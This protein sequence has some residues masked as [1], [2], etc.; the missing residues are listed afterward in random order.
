M[1]PHSLAPYHCPDWVTVRCG[2]TRDNDTGKAERTID[3]PTSRYK[4]PT[5]QQ[6]RGSEKKRKKKTSRATSHTLTILILDLLVGGVTSGIPTPTRPLCRIIGSNAK[7]SVRE[8]REAGSEAQVPE[9]QGRPEFKISTPT[10]MDEL[11]H[12]S[13]T[14]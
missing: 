2:H 9:A 7:W 13:R 6:G 4:T 1:A 3:H 12:T 11:A 8:N 14:K 10:D 5:W